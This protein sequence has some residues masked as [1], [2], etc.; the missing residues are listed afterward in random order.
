M[1][2]MPESAR[3]SLQLSVQ[4]SPL[5]FPLSVACTLPAAGIDYGL[6]L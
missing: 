2:M 3:S 5:L 1:H 6:S 4:G